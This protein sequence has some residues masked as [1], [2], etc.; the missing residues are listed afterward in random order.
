MAV[1]GSVVTLLALVTAMVSPAWGLFGT[2]LAVNANGLSTATLLP[3]TGFTV[4]VNCSAAITLRSVTSASTDPAAGDPAGQLTVAKP[5]G[6]QANDVMV[7]AIVWDETSGTTPPVNWTEIRTDVDPPT[8]NNASH[9]LFYRVATASEPAV[10]QFNAIGSAPEEA[11]AVLLAYSGVDS[12]NPI[13][14]HSGATEPDLVDDLIPAPSVTTSLPGARLI[15]VFEESGLSSI[16]PPTGMVER[17]EVVVTTSDFHTF[18]VADETLAVAGPTGSRTAREP[19]NN[20]LG[21]G[22]MV[23]LR[24]AT[25]TANSATITWTPTPST[26]A[27]SYDLRR[28]TGATLGFQRSISPATASSATDSPLPSGTTYRYELNARFNN[29]TSSVVT[30]NVTPNCA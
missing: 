7:F 6:T 17:A 9:S 15:G 21:T 2:S 10:Y 13:D 30:A 27:A 25:G 24:P 29:W 4:A 12:A 23:A 11:A 16:D 28:Y 3:P 18:E 5:A 26:F 22:Q 8:P 1:Q 20:N 19:G 14:A